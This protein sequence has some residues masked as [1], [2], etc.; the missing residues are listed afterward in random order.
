MLRVREAERARQYFTDLPTVTTFAYKKQPFLAQGIADFRDESA[1]P[2]G[3]PFSSSP[4]HRRWIPPSS[5]STASAW[6]STSVLAPA[7][8]VL[9]FRPRHPNAYPTARQTAE[10]GTKSEA[11]EPKSPRRPAPSGTAPGR[12]GWRSA[13]CSL[14]E[15][16]SEGEEERESAGGMCRDGGVNVP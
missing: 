2:A 8:S 7:A 15:S 6:S 10:K 3:L 11:T 1:L 14:E 4:F 12:S 16:E 5:A 13:P 9:P